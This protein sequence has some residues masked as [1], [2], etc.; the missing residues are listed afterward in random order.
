MKY[1]QSI[2]VL[3]DV[4]TSVYAINIAPCNIC[5][6]PRQVDVKA[7][8]P[9]NPMVPLHIF[10]VLGAYWCNFQVCMFGARACVTKDLI[11]TALVFWSG[12]IT[13]HHFFEKMK[14]RTYL[15]QWC[16]ALA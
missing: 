7:D 15:V 4:T 3:R 2:S 10:I 16:C 13:I 14:S 1:H 12:A 8:T 6:L 11:M 9:Q 5:G